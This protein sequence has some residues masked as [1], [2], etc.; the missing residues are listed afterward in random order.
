MARTPLPHQARERQRQRTW[1]VAMLQERGTARRSPGLPLS[2]HRISC[3]IQVTRRGCP[4][5]LEI[6][7]R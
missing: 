1:I 7:N 2:T 5:M 3:V 6:V 4:T